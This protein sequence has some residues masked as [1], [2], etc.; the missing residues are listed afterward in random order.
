MKTTSNLPLSSYINCYF[1]AQ[2]KFDSSLF[3]IIFTT[4][5]SS[6]ANNCC[7]SYETQNIIS[8][9]TS[10][11]SPI[12]HIFHLP[13]LHTKKDQRIVGLS[14]THTKFSP[15]PLFLQLIAHSPPY[16]KYLYIL[17]QQCPFYTITPRQ[18]RSDEG[19]HNSLLCFTQLPEN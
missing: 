16:I 12:P 19:F 11:K 5:I 13:R 3:Y 6:Y 2:Y 18:S 7:H 9:S 14:H 17:S 10:K 1:Y 8:L 4:Q 15:T